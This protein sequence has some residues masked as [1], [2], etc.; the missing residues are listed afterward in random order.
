MDFA[1]LSAD[2][3][4]APHPPHSLAAHPLVAG[5]AAASAAGILIAAAVAVKRR[6]AP[7]TAAPTVNML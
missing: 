6:A 5:L 4:A 7:N 2:S 3:A 1:F